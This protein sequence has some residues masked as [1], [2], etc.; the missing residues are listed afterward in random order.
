MSAY[1]IEQIAPNTWIIFDEQKDA[2][3]LLAGKEKAMLIDTTMA[4][5]P[6]ME[7][8]RSLTNLPV[9]LYL[10]HGHIDHIGRSGEFDQ[11]YM[12]YKDKDL[13]DLFAK[14]DEF[15]EAPLDMIDSDQIHDLDGIHSI[16]LGER[17]IQIV[18]LAGHTKGSVVFVD[19]ENQFVYTGDALGSGCGLWLFDD[20]SLDITDYRKSLEKAKADL[21]K[22]GVTPAWKFQGGHKDQEYMSKVS[23]YNRL[24]L[25]LLSDMIELCNLDLISTLKRDYVDPAQL[26][27]V[28]GLTI[29]PF[30]IRHGKAE[31]L[32]AEQKLK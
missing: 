1:S 25:N 20:N 14:G 30:N 12:S 17:V 10:T 15:K 4:M 2:A 7:T 32:T 9:D 5:E 26:P 11:V 22:L 16:D 27:I 19:P 28:K 23:D 31:M 13:Y 29:K 21:E 18:P 8:I 6:I 24:D 3:Y